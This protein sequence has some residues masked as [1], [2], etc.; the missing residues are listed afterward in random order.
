M[1][2]FKQLIVDIVIDFLFSKKISIIEN[3]IQCWIC[4]NSQPIKKYGQS[5]A[6]IFFFC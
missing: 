4:Q 1:L 2:K 3:I 5:L 6:T